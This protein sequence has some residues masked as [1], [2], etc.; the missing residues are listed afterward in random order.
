MEPYAP[1]LQPVI[2]HARG[3]HSSQNPFQ[4]SIGIDTTF[5]IDGYF[6]IRTLTINHC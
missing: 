5:M 3:C 6:V 4:N 2:K 1:A